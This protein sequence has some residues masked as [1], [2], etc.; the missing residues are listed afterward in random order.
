[1][2]AVESTEQI[3]KRWRTEG[4]DF[5][6]ADLVTEWQRQAREALRERESAVLVAAQAP[7]ASEHLREVAASIR[8][9]RAAGNYT[10]QG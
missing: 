2:T 1:M 10:T 8:D 4:R 5:R 9:H 6:P 7:D 3:A